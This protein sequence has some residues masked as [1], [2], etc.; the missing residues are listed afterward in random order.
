M[1][2]ARDRN[3]SAILLALIV[4]QSLC[5]AFFLSDAASDALELG[6]AAFG[7][8]HL[9]LE[10]AAAL[11]LVAAVA[12]EARFLQVLM[13]RK[14]RLEQ[15]L[16]IAAG[17]LHEVIDRHFRDW[18]LTPAESDVALFTIKG[19]SIAEIADLRG[20]AQGTV[21]SQL[22]AIY[23]KSGVTGRGGLLALL[24]EDLLDAPLLPEPRD[25]A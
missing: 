23:R 7:D 15:N 9:W 4:V 17:A 11:S 1:T 25:A 21:K 18:G 20:S 3:L 8:W 10:S 2:I 5:A 14:A 22:N 6:A 16:S 13:R 24:I 19:L 12:I